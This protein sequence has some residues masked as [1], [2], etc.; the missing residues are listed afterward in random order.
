MAVTKRVNHVVSLLIHREMRILKLKKLL[1]II[2]I[3]FILF[4]GI[5]FVKGFVTVKDTFREEYE[6]FSLVKPGMGEQ[7]V[8]KLLGNPYKIYFR[9]TA[10]KDYY[11]SGYAYKKREIIN[12]VFIYIGTEPIAYIYFDNQNKV[13]D[14]FIGGS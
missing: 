14:I 7:E 13:E 11:I 4:I 5:F 2:V 8:V 10:P 1:T 6:R 9:T 3:I 12:K